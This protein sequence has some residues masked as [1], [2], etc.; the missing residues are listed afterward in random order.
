[1]IYKR[2]RVPFLRTAT[3]P[4]LITYVAAIDCRDTFISFIPQS[5]ANACRRAAR[6]LC[7][8]AAFK[9]TRTKHLINRSTVQRGAFAPPAGSAES[10]PVDG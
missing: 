10:T 1:M 6:M 2:F 3:P 4:R 9:R 8:A 5:R 7:G